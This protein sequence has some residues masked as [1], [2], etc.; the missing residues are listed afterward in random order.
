MLARLTPAQV[1]QFWEAIKW[2]IAKALPYGENDKTFG[3]ILSAINNQTLHVF[4]YMVEKDD[5]Q[6]I[7]AVITTTLNIDHITNEK[8]FIIY[9]LTGNDGLSEEDMQQGLQGLLNHAKGLNCKR[10]IAYTKADKVRSL[11]KKL[12]FEETSTLLSLEV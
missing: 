4:V 2:H 10:I 8:N 3:S 9:T 6:V 7:K 11:A 5:E 1:S 12:G